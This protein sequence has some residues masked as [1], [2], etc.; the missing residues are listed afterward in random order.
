MQPDPLQKTG[1]EKKRSREGSSVGSFCSLGAGLIFLFL[2]PGAAVKTNAGE[3]G[4]E[5][6]RSI[7]V[8]L[9]DAEQLAEMSA[10][11]DEVRSLRGRVRK[12]EAD[13]EGLRAENNLLRQELVE[14]FEKFSE[15][16][17]L[18][19]QM[20]LGVAGA[21]AEG[22]WPE[23]DR[24]Y[25]QLVRKFDEIVKG[26]VRVV[27]ASLEF[28]DEVDSLLADEVVDG[29]ELVRMRLKR[30][31]VKSEARKFNMLA[32]REQAADSVQSSRILAVDRDLQAVILPVGSVHGA[33][34]GLIF[35]VSGKETN[36]L[37][38]VLTRPFISMAIVLTGSMDE[39]AP[40]M[41]VA[42]EASNTTR[43]E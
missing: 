20:Q 33:F 30:D 25:M 37:K 22:K 7:K 26:G 3:V 10:L 8:S 39:I 12:L 15:Q 32:G 2:A 16:D 28:C 41:E 42:A 43:E 29:A 36:R 38:V 5:S 34:N 21:L 18:F 27:L 1:R 6:L 9:R 40:G 23:P 13:A 17:A 35:N 14:I 31:A 11:T 19:H 4:E 24:R